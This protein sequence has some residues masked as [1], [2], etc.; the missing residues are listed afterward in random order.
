MIETIKHK[1]L[2]FGYIIKY[3]KK[4][5]VN[6]LTPSNLTQQIGSI[7][8]NK[9]H[10]ILPHLHLV[11]KRKIEYTSEVLIIQKGKIRVDLYSDKKNIYLVKL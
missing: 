3:K 9:N 10:E 1:K 4:K 2:I 8:H 5:G 11:N 6:F 7:R